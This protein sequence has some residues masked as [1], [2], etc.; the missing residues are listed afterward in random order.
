VNQPEH[1]ERV[2]DPAVYRLSGRFSLAEAVRQVAAAIAFARAE[3]IRRLMVVLLGLTGFEL[4]DVTSRYFYVKDWAEASGGV[5]RVAF[6]VRP[7]RIERRGFD[8]TVA[9]NRGFRAAVFETE[10][11]ALSWLRGPK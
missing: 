3:R 10:E 11:Q 8:V 7:E 2:G 4:P 6:V 5:V 9:R 1:F